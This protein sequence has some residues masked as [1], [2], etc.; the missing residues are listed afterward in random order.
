MLPANG[1]ELPALPGRG[2]RGIEPED[3]PDRVRVENI[4]IGSSVQ[5]VRSVT[6]SP[7]LACALQEVGRADGPAD[8]L[9][10]GRA[11]RTGGRSMA[12]AYAPMGIQGGFAV[13]QNEAKKE[14]DMT[15]PRIAREEWIEER[16]SSCS[17]RR[18]RSPAARRPE[19][20]Q[21]R[22]ADGGIIEGVRSSGA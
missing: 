2:D 9:P 19:N 20:E 17:T 12:R 15:L 4:T 13:T 10:G 6:G 16:A 18:R 21:A 7:A 14:S 5:K 22:P 8:R 1:R 11:A 3:L